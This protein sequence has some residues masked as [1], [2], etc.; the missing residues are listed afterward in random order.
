MLR[1]SQALSP[2][3]KLVILGCIL[4]GVIAAPA[5][6]LLRARDARGVYLEPI[7]AH[8]IQSTVLASGHLEYER[9]AMLTAEETGKVVALFVQEG[10]RVARG[11]IL[12]QI[13]DEALRAAVQQS[14]A[15]V[16]MQ[17]SGVRRD[18]VRLRDLRLQWERKRQ[19][20]ER[21]LIS[22]ESYDTATSDLHVAE[23]N[24]DESRASLAQTRA[25]LQQAEARLRKT[26]A[27]AP[28]DGVVT[29]LDIKV[30]ETAVTSSVNIPGSNL[31]TIAYP[32]SIYTEVFVDEADIAN[33]RVGQSAQVHA[34]G[35][36]DRAIEAVVES[37]AGS[38]KVAEHTQGLSF[39]VK[40]RFSAAKPMELRSGMSCRAEI[41]TGTRDEVPA[42]PVQALLAEKERGSQ[43]S[44]YFLFRNENGIA[45][46]VNVEVGISDD[47][48]QE[49]RSGVRTGDRIVT[50]P[51]RV[52]QK[53]LGGER[54]SSIA[55]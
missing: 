27:Y 23:A 42:V 46:K 49:I 37:I 18:E 43:P 5:S 16:Q 28:I 33:V 13:D 35:Y 4:A 51:D 50:G 20:Q 48:F 34:V 47:S 3:T 10:Q 6:N 17:E 22:V 26:R 11:Q 40:M 9:K 7:A 44:K 53:L 15:A 39:A 2:R 54:I 14:Q 41:V 8:L 24:L 30:G 31:M 29:S 25:Q 55:P 32:E 45:R 19:L 38:A 52:L 36:P 1:A 21:R 12:L